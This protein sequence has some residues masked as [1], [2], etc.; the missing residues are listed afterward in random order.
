MKYIV[1]RHQLTS[2]LKRRFSIGQ[3]DE[4]VE[5]V[6]EE[7][8]QDYHQFQMN[9]NHKREDVIYDIVREFIL[10]NVSDIVD[11]E[12]ERVYWDSYLKYEI[13]LIEFVKSSLNLN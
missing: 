6:Q 2:F 12:D 11:Q 8:N 10:L 7:M 1:T 3:L 4:L 13:P 9:Q 5:R